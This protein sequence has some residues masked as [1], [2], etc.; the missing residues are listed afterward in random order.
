MNYKGSVPPSKI[1]SLLVD[2][3]IPHMPD[4]VSVTSPFMSVINGLESIAS[5]KP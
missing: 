5:I 4:T 3:S 2:H 1:H